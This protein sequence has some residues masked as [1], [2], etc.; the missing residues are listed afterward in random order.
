MQKSI[1][2]LTEGK[3]NCSNYEH[4]III[5]LLTLII[6]GI[7]FLIIEKAYRMPLFRK[8]QYSNEIKVMIFISNIN[9]MSQL[10]YVKLQVVYIC[11]N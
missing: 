6:L 8:H 11:L 3:E 1:K 2:A 7:I 4:W 10:G 5:I 9:L